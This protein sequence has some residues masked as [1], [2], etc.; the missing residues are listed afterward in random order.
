[1]VIQADFCDDPSVTVGGELP[2]YINDRMGRDS[3]ISGGT[4]GR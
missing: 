4:D 3:P 2:D 1:M